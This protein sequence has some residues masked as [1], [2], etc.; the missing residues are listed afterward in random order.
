MSGEHLGQD[1]ARDQGWEGLRTYAL[2]QMAASSQGLGSAFHEQTRRACVA[3]FH[4]ASTPGQHHEAVM[5]FKA[6]Q[7]R[8][9][10]HLDGISEAVE[11]LDAYRN[12]IDGVTPTVT[13]QQFYDHL[14]QREF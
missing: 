10:A 13:V 9:A 7:G 3:A 4:R 1:R 5:E 11:M 6:W 8:N 14:A 12:Y 2:R